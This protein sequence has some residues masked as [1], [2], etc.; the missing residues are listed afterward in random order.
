[1]AT[2]RNTLAKLASVLTLA[3]IFCASSV[4]TANA[5]D[6]APQAGTRKVLT[7]NGVDFAFRYCPPG[8]FTMGSPVSEAGRKDNETQCELTLTEGFWIL[9]TEVTQEMWKAVMGTNPSYFSSSGD[10]SDKVSGLDTS[11]F[12]VE[13]VSWRDWQGFLE[14]LNALGIAPAGLA[15][16]FPWEAEWE[17][18]CRA[19]TTG[20]YNVDGSSLDALGWYNGNCDEQTHAVGSKRANAWGIYDMHGNVCEWCADWPGAWYT[21]EYWLGDVGNGDVPMRVLRGGYWLGGAE[22]CRSAKKVMLPETSSGKTNGGRLVLAS[23]DSARQQRTIFEVQQTHA[24][25]Q[26]QIWANLYREN[27]LSIRRIMHEDRMQT[28]RE[29]IDELKT[30]RKLDELQRELNELERERAR[31]RGRF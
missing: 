22:L 29:K 20:P 2:R 18:A 21:G 17:Y 16:R 28:Y 6:S 15:F 11:R 9:E 8:S 5:W 19:G 3:C 14:K 30:Q 26:Q 23:G 12:P 10:G 25:Q 13:R 7:I 1:M 24:G 4:S 27:E 31:E